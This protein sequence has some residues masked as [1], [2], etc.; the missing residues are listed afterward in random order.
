MVRVVVEQALTKAATNGR[1]SRV[2][3]LGQYPE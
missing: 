2:K 3:L 1:G